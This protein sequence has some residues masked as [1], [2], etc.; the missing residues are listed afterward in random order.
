MSRLNL[1]IFSYKYY[2]KFCVI[3]DRCFRSLKE[4]IIRYKY[5]III[6]SILF[7]IVFAT[8]IFT[9]LKY[10]KDLSPDNFINKTMLEFLKKEK[11]VFSL[12]LSYYFWF[13]LLS[14]IAMFFTVN[15]FINIIEILAS[16]LLVYIIGFDLC[17]MFFSFGIVGIIFS[18]FV[19]GLI[20]MLSF[21]CFIFIIS[22]STRLL[23]SGNYVC[24]RSE[25]KEILKTYLFFLI[26]LTILLYLLCMTLTILHIFVII[27]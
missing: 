22:I 1:L 5:Y 2:M 19:Y 9:A 16:L 26:I 8:G 24:S 10:S 23:K 12:F 14:F 6:Y 7:V 3:K 21:I 4:L 11:G 18:I 27:D 25:K 13:F 15:V 17:V 20:M